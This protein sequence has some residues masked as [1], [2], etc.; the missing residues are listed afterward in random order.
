MK[1]VLMSI[2]LLTGIIL[3]VGLGERLDEVVAYDSLF[4]IQGSDTY[5][6]AEKA[7]GSSAVYLYF[8]QEKEPDANDCGDV[9]RIFGKQGIL[10]VAVMKTRPE[11][12][13][14]KDAGNGESNV[15]SHSEYDFQLISAGLYFSRQEF[16]DKIGFY[17]QDWKPEEIECF[18][19]S[20]KVAFSLYHDY[21]NCITSTNGSLYGQCVRPV[22][23]TEVKR[24]QTLWC[25]K[26]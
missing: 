10:D 20:M 23:R 14:I 6:R 24:Y 26:R 5:V 4:Y 19:D 15:I 25:G 1:R 8:R 2:A 7:V 3:M 11:R 18:R 12:I 17:Y 16:D 9:V 21:T 13:L 22:K